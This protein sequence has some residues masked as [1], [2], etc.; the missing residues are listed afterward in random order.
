M[1]S[2]SFFRNPKILQNLAYITGEK[3]R[4]IQPFLADFERG[5][6]EGG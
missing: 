6:Q 1:H 5:C 3:L 2:C 4:Y